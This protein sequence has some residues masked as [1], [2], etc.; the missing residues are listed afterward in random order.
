VAATLGFA[1]FGGVGAANAAITGPSSGASYSSGSSVTVTGTV[2]SGATL[3]AVA[4]C[5]TSV[6]AS[7]GTKCNGTSTTRYTAVTA[8][9][10][11]SRSIVV[12]RTFTNV[13]F[14][15]GTA[16][17]STTCKNSVGS[18]TQCG[19]VVSYYSG[20]TSTPVYVTSE[21]VNIAIN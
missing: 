6:P 7:I 3:Y 8:G 18:G 13:N 17:G 12:D 2:P 20:T 11:Y 9:T 1:V 14:T 15:G 21:Y 10:S 5:D 4:S 16:T 19:V